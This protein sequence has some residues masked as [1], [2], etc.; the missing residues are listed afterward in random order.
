MKR[1]W[2]KVECSVEKRVY[3]RGEKEGTAAKLWLRAAISS[4]YILPLGCM[5]G[6]GGF[7]GQPALDQGRCS[8][9]QTN[10]AETGLFD[11][12]QHAGNDRRTRLAK[13][14]ARK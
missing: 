11:D 13:T 5:G 4:F 12:S 1:V 9:E 3:G 8:A 7:A 10:P 14:A 6:A 2:R